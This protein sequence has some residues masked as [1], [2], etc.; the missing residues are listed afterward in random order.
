MIKVSAVSYLNTK[1]FVYGLVEKGLNRMMDLSLDIPSMCA[2]KLISGQADLGL[3]PVAIIP[4]L[5]TPHIISDFCI[6]SVG[7]VKTVCLYSHQ[8][9]E[10]VRRVWLDYQSRTSVQLTKTLLKYHWK[11]KPQLVQAQPGYERNAAHD[12]AVLVIGDRTI[13]LEDAYP[14]VYDLGAAWQ[15]F[16]GLPFVYAAWVSNR[17][18]PQEFIQKFNAALDFGLHNLH[19]VIHKYQAASPDFSLKDYYTKYINYHLDQPKREALEVFLDYVKG[20]ESQARYLVF[21]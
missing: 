8:P 14:F 18:L 6:G 20:K 7:A 19:K 17:A 10:M 11:L 1:P 12:E 9:L 4:K 21:C 16:T 13:G 2:E 15:D 5:K 3:I